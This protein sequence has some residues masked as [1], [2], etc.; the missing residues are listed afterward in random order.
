MRTGV[1]T[2]KSRREHHEDSDGLNEAADV[3]LPKLIVRQVSDRAVNQHGAHDVAARKPLATR[4]FGDMHEVGDGTR[5][6]RD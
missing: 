3:S 4:P 2:S 1:D 5:A 6:R